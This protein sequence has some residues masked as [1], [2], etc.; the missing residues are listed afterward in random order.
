MF[1]ELIPLLKIILGTLFVLVWLVEVPRF[2][3][4]NRIVD[5]V[6]K[7][8]A[9]RRNAF[10]RAT[11]MPISIY[12]VLFWISPIYLL[13]FPGIIYF[14]FSGLFNYFSAFMWLMYIFILLDY[15]YCKS[16]LSLIDNR[17]RELNA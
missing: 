5:R 10:I 8:P 16:V 17:K 6:I 11:A 12:K 9:E 14:Y 13:L 4:R 3:L 15:F 7:L 1:D 2:F